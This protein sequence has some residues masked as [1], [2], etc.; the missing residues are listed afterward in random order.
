M[1]SRAA[2]SHDRS[3]TSCQNYNL[4]K[5]LKTVKI[6]Y[7]KNFISAFCKKNAKQAKIGGDFFLS[8]LNQP[9]GCGWLMVFRYHRPS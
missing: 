5:L 8:G 9:N 2:K 6:C 3:L 7:F 4:F 1:V